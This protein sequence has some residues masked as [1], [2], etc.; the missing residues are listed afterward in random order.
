MMSKTCN[1]AAITMTTT[2]SRASPA[3]SPIPLMRRTRS[4]QHLLDQTQ[5]L[6]RLQ[7]LLE[8]QLQPAA[9]EHCRVAAWNNGCLLL[10]I[11]NSH[12]ATRLRYQQRRLQ[13]KLA[14]IE[15]FANIS[16]ICFKVQP[17]TNGD[18][19]PDQ[20]FTLS[21]DASNTLKETARGISDPKLKAALERL[22][23]RTSSWE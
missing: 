15:E 21:T 5:R 22:A 23:S 11:S 1:T 13:S 3:Q 12:W 16:K 8:S 6:D 17:S 19:D 10:I 7:C 18:N 9:R 4:L 20:G 14:T 2:L